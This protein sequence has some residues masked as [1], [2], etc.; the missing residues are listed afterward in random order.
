[1]LSSAP[2]LTYANQLL[3]PA[4][5]L[6]C[7]EEGK[8]SWPLLH[9]KVRCSRDGT[10]DAMSTVSKLPTSPR[11]GFSEFTRFAH[12]SSSPHSLSL[13]PGRVPS[14]HTQ[15]EAEFLTSTARIIDI[16][17]HACRMHTAPALL[18]SHAAQATGKEADN[19]WRLHLV[20]ARKKRHPI[21]KQASTHH[22]MCSYNS[23]TPGAIALWTCILQQLYKP[24]YCFRFCM[25]VGG[26][27]PASVRCL[28][29][30]RA[31]TSQRLQT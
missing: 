27:S 15:T 22:A 5:A 31:A 12:L 2:V 17:S 20:A 19:Q 28:V 3:I 24:S 7:A 18:Q 6:T 11:A 14:K 13:V 30:L 21:Q 1:L 9:G 26:D 29:V 8:R 25:L 10:Q 16:M 4:P 23:V